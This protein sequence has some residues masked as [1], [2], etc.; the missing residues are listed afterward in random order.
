[1]SALEIRFKKAAD[2]SA[3]LACIRSDGS[4]TWQKD[5]TGGFFPIHDLTHYSVE[6]VLGFRR[7]F[8]GVISEGWNLTD[9]GPPWP[10]GPLPAE[11]LVAEHLVGLLDLESASGQRMTAEE[12]NAALRMKLNEPLGAS[13]VREVRDDELARI[14]ETRAELVARWR[15]LRPGDTMTLRL[16][17]DRP[18]S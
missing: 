2:G 12:V 1:M 3:S 8:F 9:F 6:T 4:T 15:N 11:A 7:A 10:H 13:A 16:E 18:P 5:R 14:R 17:A